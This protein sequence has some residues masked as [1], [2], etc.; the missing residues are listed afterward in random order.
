MLRD[1][2]SVRGTGSLSFERLGARARVTARTTT[3]FLFFSQLQR[4][5][6]L[7]CERCWLCAMAACDNKGMRYDGSMSVRWDEE[8]EREEALER[9][10]GRW[11]FLCWLLDGVAVTATKR[12]DPLSLVR[13]LSL[14]KQPSAVHP[15]P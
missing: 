10:Q 14:P 8:S 15:R 9:E 1:A 2:L 12:S 4:A 11:L 6:G 3:G 7:L 13:Q 5:L